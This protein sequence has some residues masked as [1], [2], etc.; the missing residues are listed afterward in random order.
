MLPR[1]PEEA[2]QAL[3]GALG[4][5]EQAIAEGRDAIHNLRASTVVT[6]EL[7]QAVTSL[8]NE[9]T[10]EGSPSARFHV[11]VEGSTH[12]LHP[13][14]RDEVY[15]ITREAVRNAFRHAQAHDIE[16]EITYNVGSFRL[17]VRDDGKG[18]DPAIVAEGRVGHYGVPGMRERAKR[19]GG[20]LDVWTE[21]G[22][23]TEIELSIPGSI[24]YGTSAG[25]TVLGLFRKKAAKS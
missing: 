24:A 12:E 5:T 2:M 7:A 3:D 4:R 20:K 16:V 25:R 23:G 22:A 15:A 19:I 13:I 18:I 6:N 8:G 9:M 14:L 17:R 1:R 21:T 11:A 10:R